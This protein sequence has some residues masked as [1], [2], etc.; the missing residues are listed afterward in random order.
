MES[1][2]SQHVF[3]HID[4]SLQTQELLV[5]I[6]ELLDLIRENVGMRGTILELPNIITTP[7]IIEVVLSEQ[8]FRILLTN[9]GALL[10]SVGI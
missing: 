4:V 2:S 7:S 3:L 10:S 5:N 8:N 9:R 6:Q 1:R